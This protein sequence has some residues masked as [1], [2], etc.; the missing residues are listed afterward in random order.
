M[1]AHAAKRLQNA[2]RIFEGDQAKHLQ[3]TMHR[4]LTHAHKELIPS[5]LAYG[6]GGLPAMTAHH[7]ECLL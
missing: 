4:R 6:F 2:L 7:R 3:L 5:E 1:T